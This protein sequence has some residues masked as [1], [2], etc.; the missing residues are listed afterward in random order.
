MDSLLKGLQKVSRSGQEPIT[1]E[2]VDLNEILSRI[3]ESLTPMMKKHSVEISIENLPP[4]QGDIF[5]LGIV[6]SNL[7][8]NAIKFYDPNRSPWIKVRGTI[9]HERA[10][11]R[12]EDNGIGIN[13]HDLDKIFHLFYRVDPMRTT[14]DGLGLTISR[15][16]LSRMFGDI[17][18]E[19]II[20][21]GS[22]FTISMPLARK[23]VNK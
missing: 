6:F 16:A 15:Q 10:I 9:E 3:V 17:R 13:S 7:I 5:Q 18:V 23:A 1:I 2:T 19:S 11:Y 21:Q 12:V 4:C 14:G 22:I 8:S 20:G